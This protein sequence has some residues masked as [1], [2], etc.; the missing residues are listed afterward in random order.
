MF[1]L[2]DSGCGSMGRAVTSTPEVPEFDSSHRQILRIVSNVGRSLTNN[3][4]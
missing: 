3:I 1:D 4:S 2:V